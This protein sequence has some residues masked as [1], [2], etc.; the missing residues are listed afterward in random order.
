M[1]VQV[2]WYLWVEYSGTGNH[3]APGPGQVSADVGSR[4]GAQLRIRLYTVLSTSLP[5]T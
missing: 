5:A 3:A 1:L 2:P 4:G